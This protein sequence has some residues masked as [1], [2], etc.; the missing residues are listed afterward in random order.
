MSDGEHGNLTQVGAAM[1][2]MC[3]FVAKEEQAGDFPQD[4]SG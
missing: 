1:R 3:V 2:R 4:Q